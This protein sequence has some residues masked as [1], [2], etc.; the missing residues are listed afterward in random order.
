MIMVGIIISRFIY[1]YGRFLKKFL[2]GGGNRNKNIKRLGLIN[3]SSS[4][5]KIHIK[6]P[7]FATK[8]KG[9]GYKIKMIFKV[10]LLFF[11]ERLKSLDRLFH[12]PKNKKKKLWP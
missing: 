7:N 1:L 8:F 9:K 10:Q 6:M 12:K 3:K 2:S 11:L 5:T 4:Q